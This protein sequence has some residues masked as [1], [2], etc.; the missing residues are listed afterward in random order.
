VASKYAI[1]ILPGALRQIEKLPAA[2]QEPVR[3]AID[4]LASDPRPVG[5]E[6]MTVIKVHRVRVADYR[7]LYQVFDAR[8]VVLVVRV[9]DRRE[10]YS[11]TMIKRLRKQLESR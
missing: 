9:A 2:S 8:L 4:A 7:I 6:T 10:V 3:D 1:Q 5:S 11:Q